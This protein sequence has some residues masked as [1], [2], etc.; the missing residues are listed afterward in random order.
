M[1]QQLL[2]LLTQLQLIVALMS[3]KNTVLILLISVITPNGGD[4]RTKL[5]MTLLILSKLQLTT[6]QR[7]L[8]LLT[9]VLGINAGLNIKLSPIFQQRDPIPNLPDFDSIVP[10]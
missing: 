10:G 5:P 2:P 9:G 6:P 8:V 7:P 1:M 3:L 4:A